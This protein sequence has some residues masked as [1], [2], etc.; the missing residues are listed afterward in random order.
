MVRAMGRISVELEEGQGPSKVRTLQVKT[1]RVLK[2]VVCGGGTEWILRMWEM[3]R[4][5][6]VEFSDIDHWVQS[7]A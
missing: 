6:Q 3:A 7:C 4:L 5:G 1:H 2:S